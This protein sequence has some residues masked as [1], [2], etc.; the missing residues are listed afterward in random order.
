MTRDGAPHR[1]LPA[2]TSQNTPR[3]SAEPAQPA[4]DGKLEWFPILGYHRV[5]PAI[6]GPDPYHLSTTVSAFGA[7]MRYLKENGY[8]VVDLREAVHLASMRMSTL[9]HVAITFDDGYRDVFVH[10]V[11]ILQKY[12]FGATVFVVSDAIGGVNRWDSESGRAREAPIVGIQ[13]LREALRN[14]MTVGSHSC[15]HRPLAKIPLKEAEREIAESKAA[16]EQAAGVEVRAFCYPYGSSN[17]AVRS[18]AAESG[19]SM[20]CGVEERDHT[21]FNL[22]R[23]DAAACH[24]S[25][26]RWLLRLSGARFRAR[27][28]ASIVKVAIKAFMERVG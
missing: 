28:Q 23:I 1:E 6:E 17:S 13:E 8:K 21:L 19:Y 7:Q 18:M 25:G 14:G 5:V 26:L 3:G 22:S 27:E 12:H 10:A 11:P 16:L 9:K 15:T 2:E 20:A 4:R 24:G